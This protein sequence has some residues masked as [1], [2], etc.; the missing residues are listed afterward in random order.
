VRTF[1]ILTII[2]L[3]ALPAVANASIFSLFE[4]A[5]RV[6]GRA[7]GRLGSAGAKSAAAFLGLS[8]AEKALIAFSSV[9]TA[10]YFITRD[11]ADLVAFV[12]GMDRKISLS[13]GSKPDWITA[14][15]QTTSHALADAGVVFDSRSGF[16]ALPDFSRFLHNRDVYVFDPHYG[17][18]RLRVAPDGRVYVELDSGLLLPAGDAAITDTLADLFYQPVAREDI[19]VISSFTKDDPDSLRRILDVGGDKVSSLTSMLDHTGTLMLKEKMRGRILIFVGHVENGSFV[20]LNAG[21]EKIASVPLAS[22]Q[23]QAAQLNATVIFLGCE[24][25]TG[26]GW[27]GF[28]MKIRDLQVVSSLAQA[29]EARSYRDLLSA[30]GTADNPFVMRVTSLDPIAAKIALNLERL[31]KHEASTRG[32][33]TVARIVG[34]V[35]AIKGLPEWVGGVVFY[36]VVGICVVLIGHERA[37]SSFERK[38]PRLPSPDLNPLYFHIGRSVKFTIFA[39]F[40]PIAGGLM[41]IWVLLGGWKTRE[42]M[43]DVVW[44]SLFRFDEG[45]LAASGVVAAVAVNAV[46]SLCWLE[47]CVLIDSTLWEV[48]EASWW[49]FDFLS[50]MII[51]EIVVGV[52][53]AIYVWRRTE[54]VIALFY[55]QIYSLRLP[56]ALKSIMAHSPLLVLLMGGVVLYVGLN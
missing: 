36:Y 4:D 27:T 7:G 21:G 51:A 47:A 10:G 2:A 46:P 43:Y 37:W 26:T 23:S 3:L 42:L 18:K 38:F 8:Q 34:Q 52:K 56:H 49:G 16:T 6:G 28:L 48:G 20:T 24:T 14:F 35:H 17:A 50:M 15:S 29:L 25:F 41:A 54:Y 39:L 44:T 22:I 53:L 9:A 55:Y 31:H 45:L 1:R 30:L 12:R 5:A 33:A 40:S 11:G 19:S 13:T 32:G